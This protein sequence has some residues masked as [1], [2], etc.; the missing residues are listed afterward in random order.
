MPTI[1]IGPVSDEVIAA[2]A[3]MIVNYRLSEEWQVYGALGTDVFS[4][5]ANLQVG[6]Y[7]SPARWFGLTANAKLVA[8]DD[9]TNAMLSVAPVFLVHTDRKK[10]DR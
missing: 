10:D 3:G 5:A 8:G 6:T 4:E 2:Q 1:G 9:G 7:W